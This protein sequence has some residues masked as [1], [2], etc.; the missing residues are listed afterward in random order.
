M[1]PAGEAASAVTG[2]PKF[3]TS[4]GWPPDYDREQAIAAAG[5]QPA[6]GRNQIVRRGERR[7]LRRLVEADV[8]AEGAVHRRDGDGAAAEQV[9]DRI[10]DHGFAP[11]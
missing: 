4:T 2:E 6:A 7:Q 9:E 1:S 3:W 11:Q 10:E 5:E 8:G